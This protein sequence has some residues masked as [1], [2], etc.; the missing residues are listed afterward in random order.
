MNKT[1]TLIAAVIIVAI[2][3]I[4]MVFFLHVPSSTAPTASSTSASHTSSSSKSS[5]NG[6][7]TVQVENATALSENYGV[8]GQ[9]FYV[10][11]QVHNELSRTLY[12]EPDEVKLVTSTGSYSPDFF[13]GA[14]QPTLEV[15]PGDT[16]NVTYPFVI[17]FNSVPEKVE[18]VNST[19]NLLTSV[20]FPSPKAYV[21][22]VRLYYSS[23]DSE[24]STGNTGYFK[25]ESGKP[26]QV[27]VSVYSSHSSLPVLIDEV[28]GSPYVKLDSPVCI[29][30]HS[31]GTLNLTVNIP[32]ESY[33]GTINLVFLSLINSSSISFKATPINGEA[34]ALENNEQGYTCLIYN[35][36]LTYNGGSIFYPNPQDFVLI[37]NLVSAK[38]TTASFD[39]LPNSGM[40]RGVTVSGLVFF[41]VP[42]HATPVKLYYEDSDGI[43]VVSEPTSSPSIAYSLLS[44]INANVI[45]SYTDV[46]TSVPLFFSSSGF[47]G[48]NVTLTFSVYDG[49]NAPLPL[50]NVT[51]SPGFQVL[52]QNVTGKIVP[53]F[54]T[55][56]F[57][58]VAKYPEFS[59]YGPMNITVYSGVPHFVTMKVLNY[60]ID[61]ADAQAAGY[62][63]EKYLLFNLSV[64]YSGPGNLYFYPQDI[65]L[66]TNQGVFQGAQNYDNLILGSNQFLSSETMPTGDVI[67]GYV[68]FLVPSTAQP[69]QLEY[70]SSG[71][72]QAVTNINV[73]PNTVTRIEGAS[74]NTTSSAVSCYFP[75]TPFTYSSYFSGETINVSMYFQSNN[76]FSIQGWKINYPFK[77]VEQGPT[78]AKPLS[79]GYDLQT[80][81]VIEILNTSYY[82]SLHIT[83]IVSSSQTPAFLNHSSLEIKSSL[84]IDHSITARNSLNLNLL[85]TQSLFLYYCEKDATY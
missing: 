51:L 27:S 45:T 23:N 25:V 64:T 9:G 66:V 56:D 68:S 81:L 63:G 33:Y 22:M 2:A 3:V 42:A 83:A 26:Y 38:G 7:L 16:V 29:T 35:V 85:Q 10:F 82:G 73:I 39:A 74:L 80:W 31:Y 24:I 61:S 36:T 60:T 4:G 34:I 72:L 78:S 46:S 54:T 6:F 11:I 47:T 17:P 84:T 79:Y 75:S 48:Q 32:N 65:Y 77:I 19:L 30:P 50:S 40:E 28:E 52:Y 49:N 53:P 8:S 69:I 14:F 1:I 57:E 59:Y 5:S 76:Y 58:V 43:K 13:N 12:L 18:L 21:S 67:Y 62:N 44:G 15:P 71:E 37:T 20:S 55:Y 70:N 41:K